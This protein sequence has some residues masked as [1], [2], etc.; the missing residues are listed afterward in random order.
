VPTKQQVDEAIAQVCADIIQEPLLYFSEADFQQL[1]T[2][3]IKTITELKGLV[4]T[5]VRRGKNS[6]GR[7]RTS[8]V[9]R[10][11]GA[12]DNQRIDIV[13]FDQDDVS[14]IIRTNLDKGIQDYLKPRFA[15]ELGT[16]KT[17]NVCSHMGEDLAKVSKAEECGY[18][19]HIYRD[20][21]KSTS[22][23]RRENTEKKIKT[24]FRRPVWFHWKKKKKHTR[25]LAI[26]LRTERDVEKMIGKCEIFLGNG[27]NDW[28]KVN[29]SDQDKIKSKI[30]E[31]LT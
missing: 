28:Q 24:G 2:E 31:A 8:L 17:S 1:L 23:G 15:F 12:G 29:V 10:E 18:V 11:Y 5:G 4:D 9:H 6:R 27:I 20:T 16:E 25:I 19:I 14:D 13:V 22:P 30:L 26:L 3:G 21:T 7:Y